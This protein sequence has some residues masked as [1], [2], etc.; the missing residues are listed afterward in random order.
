[1]T[2]LDDVEKELPRLL[3]ARAGAERFHDVELE[4]TPETRPQLPIAGKPKFVAAVAEM[5][6]RHCADE[7]HT[8]VAPG[9]LIITGG[10]IRPELRVWNERAEVRLDVPLRPAHWEK[11]FV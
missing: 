3:V 9:D 6:I 4:V 7:A 5:Q 8:L 2:P 1:M 10:T 11:V